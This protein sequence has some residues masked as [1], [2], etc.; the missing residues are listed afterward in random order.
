MSDMYVAVQT[1]LRFEP[2]KRLTAY[3]ALSYFLKA[4]NPAFDADI[5]YTRCFGTK[6]LAKAPVRT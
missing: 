3:W 1:V 2:E 5:L 4:A 6:P